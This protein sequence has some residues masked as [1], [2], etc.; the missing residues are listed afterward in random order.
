MSKLILHLITQRDQPYGS[1]RQ[2]CE[3]CGTAS[4]ICGET[5]GWTDD[6]SVYENPPDGYDRCGSVPM[7]DPRRQT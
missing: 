7:D 1:T 3:H 2:C 4:W 5:G 6:L